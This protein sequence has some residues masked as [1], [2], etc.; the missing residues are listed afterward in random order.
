MLRNAVVTPVVGCT[1]AHFKQQALQFVWILAHQD[2]LINRVNDVFCTKAVLVMMTFP[3][4]YD[5]RIGFYLDQQTWPETNFCTYGFNIG[6]L[7]LANIRR[8]HQ[9]KVG[10]KCCRGTGNC[11]FLDKAA[12]S[13]LK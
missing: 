8:C 3:N 11:H 4:P 12:S 5:T 6:D 1:G 10:H 9:I 13:H 7:N 2:W